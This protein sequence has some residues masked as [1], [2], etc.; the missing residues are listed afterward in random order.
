M[1]SKI[2]EAKVASGRRVSALAYEQTTVKG[3]VFCSSTDC[4]ARLSFVKRHTRHYVKKNIQI[5]PCFRLKPRE[6]HAEHCKYNIKGRLQLIA[7]DSDSEIFL[8]LK[9]SKYVFRLHVLIKALW[10]ASDED[11]I[12]QGKT[13]GG[14]NASNKAFSNQGRLTN[15]LKTLGQIIELRNYCQNN[16]QLSKLV[17]LDYDGEMINWSDFYYD[18]NNLDELVSRYG[19]GEIKIPLAIAGDVYNI[20]IQGSKHRHVVELYSP[21]TGL[22]SNKLSTIST[23]QIYLTNPKLFSLID[24]SKEYVFFGKWRVIIKQ[25]GSKIYQDIKMFITEPDH[26]IEI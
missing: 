15:Y 25:K 20:D 8:A 18:R 3:K 24:P 6:S 19:A 10:T 9:Q 7:K 1:G 17:K 2:P 16:E 13:W 26:F 21:D 5:A 11:V 23:P 14:E 22:D 4:T 12:A